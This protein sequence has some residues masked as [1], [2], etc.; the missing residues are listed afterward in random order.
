MTAVYD[1][2]IEAR[3]HTFGWLRRS[4]MDK[5]VHASAHYYEAWER[6]D[7][8]IVKVR[9]QQPEIPLGNF[10]MFRHKGKPATLVWPK[11]A[12]QV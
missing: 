6:P 8:F 12:V 11:D 4:E 1:T 2:V 5:M 10:L 3:P 7:G 9:R